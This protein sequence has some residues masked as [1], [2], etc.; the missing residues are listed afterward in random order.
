MPELPE[1]ETIARHLRQGKTP[2]PG[3]QTQVIDA[4]V[5]KVLTVWPGT[6]AEPAVAQFKR[7]VNGRVIK[8]VR[9]RAKYLILDLDRGSMLIH[10]RMSGDIRLESLDRPTQPH[11][12]LI[13]ELNHR[14]R[15]A[16]NDTRKFG[17]AWW[18]KDPQ[19][20]LGKLGPEPFDPELDDDRFSRML[21]QKKRQIKPLLLDQAFIAGLGNIY[22]DEAL[23]RSRIHPRRLSSTI[24]PELAADLLEHIRQVLT[25]GIET[26][27]ASIDWVYKGGD[28]QN[29]FWVY[30]RAGAACRQCGQPIQ[31]LLVG[32]RGTHICP[33][34][35][36]EPNSK[37]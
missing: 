32:Q 34:C 29:H 1:V 36:P 25:L 11:D 2:Q 4:R 7:S 16:F 10:L 23:H 6:I 15:L 18:V 26:N 31:R 19:T 24:G 28:F 17:R 35:Q 22:T 8:S 14:D 5:T 12:R 3:D 33:E 27:G 37:D 13:L 9:R 20:I 30:G 21:S